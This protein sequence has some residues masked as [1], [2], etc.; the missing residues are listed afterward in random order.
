M[1]PDTPAHNNNGDVA[2]KVA[3]EFRQYTYSVS[4]DLGAPVRA[5]VELSKLLIDEHSASLDGEGKEFLTL[6]IENG[7]KLQGM[8]DG[9]LQYSRIHNAAAPFIKSDLNSI[10]D[11]ALVELNQKIADTKANIEVSPLPSLAVDQQQYQKL[12]YVLIDNALKFQ[13]KGRKPQI[14]I[15][16]QQKGDVWEFSVTDNGIGIA[17]QHQE[18]VFKLFQRLHTDTEYPGVGIGLTLAQ[19]IVNRHNGKVLFSAAEGG[20]TVFRFTLPG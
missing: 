11:N 6:I 3:E 2:V 10:I 14:K 17:P 8:M 7:Q 12:F 13:P 9:L 5:M 15:E 4:H 19:Q 18:K 1:T 20:G 16:A